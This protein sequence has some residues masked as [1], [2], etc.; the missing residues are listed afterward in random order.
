[1]FDTLRALPLSWWLIASVILYVLAAN[2]P[3]RMAPAAE[4]AAGGALHVFRRRAGAP[5]AAAG[6]FLYNVGVPYAALVLGLIDERAAGLS[7]LDW[8]RSLAVGAAVALAM[9]LLLAANERVTRTPLQQPRETAGGWRAASLWHALFIQAHLGFYRA[10]C[11]PAL[12]AYAGVW[13]SLGLVVGEWLLSPAWRAGWRRTDGQR[14]LSF[15]LALA[16]TTSVLFLYTGNLWVGAAVHVALALLF[17][18]QPLRTAE[19]A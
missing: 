1:M 16:L 9:A 11:A 13:V 4:S 3:W 14:V 10:V 5:V 19:P 7:G 8:S 6:S 2:L 15:D 17:G 18:V 12:G